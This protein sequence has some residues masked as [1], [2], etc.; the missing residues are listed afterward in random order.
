M[1][2]SVATSATPTTMLDP[3]SNVGVSGAE[4]ELLLDDAECRSGYVLA[5][6]TV[7]KCVLALVA[8]RAS[9]GLV[10]RIVTWRDASV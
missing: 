6:L 1:G 3:L 10:T 8:R 9:Q 5:G 7:T 2:H 4:S